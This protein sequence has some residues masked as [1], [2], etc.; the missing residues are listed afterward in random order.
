VSMYSKNLDRRLQEFSSPIIM[1]HAA[2]Y[3]ML[4]IIEYSAHVAL[5][6]QGSSLVKLL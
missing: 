5:T 4:N 6:I 2:T 1:G 3:E